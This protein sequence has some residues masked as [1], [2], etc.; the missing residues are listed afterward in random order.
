MMLTSR[1]GISR[2]LVFWQQYITSWAVT[3]NVLLQAVRYAKHKSVTTSL[4]TEKRSCSIPSTLS[5][6]ITTI[7]SQSMVSPPTKGPLISLC[8]NATDVFWRFGKFYILSCPISET[9]Y[10]HNSSVRRRLPSIAADVESLESCRITPLRYLTMTQCTWTLPET[11]QYRLFR[12]TSVW[13]FLCFTVYNAAH[14]A[15]I[16]RACCVQFRVL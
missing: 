3:N 15:D 13:I 4:V 6:S 9:W 12:E 14:S 16:P 11:G 8:N 7:H 1:S 5:L 2:N 10:A